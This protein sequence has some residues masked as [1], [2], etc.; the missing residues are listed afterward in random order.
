MLTT[1]NRDDLL[2]GGPGLD[3]YAYQA[4]IYCVDCG[5]AIIEEL[6]LSTL[7]DLTVQGIRVITESHTVAFHMRRDRW[8]RR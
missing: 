4:A 1:I 7:D 3:G 5:R 2:L 6:D 8:L